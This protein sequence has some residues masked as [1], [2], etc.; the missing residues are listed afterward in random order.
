MSTEPNR[1][2]VMCGAPTE[3]DVLAFIPRLRALGVMQFS[4]GGIS[5]TL[6]PLPHDGTAPQ[7]QAKGQP[8]DA[9]ST[10]L[11]LRGT[12]PTEAPKEVK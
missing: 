10:A 3:A 6:G 1:R 5:V 12:R 4:G 11:A 2:D 9:L 8:D 7:A